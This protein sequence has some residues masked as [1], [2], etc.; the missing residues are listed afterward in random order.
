[1]K[2]LVTGGLGGIGRH[3]SQLLLDFRMD[4]TIYQRYPTRSFKFA[5]LFPKEQIKWGDMNEIEKLRDVLA[6][7]D[8]IIH[9]AFVL[10]PM[11]ESN[12]ALARE[13]NVN[14]TQKLIKLTEEVNPNCRFIFAS[15]TTV[16]GPTA[17]LP[18]PISVDHPVNPIDEYSRQKVECE[19]ILQSSTLPW[20][21]FRISQ[22]IYLEVSATPGNL[23]RLYEFP[24]DQRVEFVHIQDVALALKNAL[25]ADCVKE[26]FI[27]AG[28]KSCQM[29]FFDQITKLCQL[30]HLPP[31]P[32]KKF[33]T[34]P[35]PLDWYNTTQSQKI[36]QYQTRTFEDYLQDLKI[37][38]GWKRKLY[39][40]VSPLARLFIHVY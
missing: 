14:A 16:Y 7:Q 13:T 40:L 36:F 15:S 2:V 4:L 37:H 17:E 39:W 12:P 28:G 35:Y 38:L 34:Q 11:S 19:K 31:P 33:S 22:A 27:I 6:E 30:Y 23:K 25:T 32:K 24:C 10:P 9:L 3:L 8:A 29:I 1:M 20:V 18:P 5:K 26:T 21:I